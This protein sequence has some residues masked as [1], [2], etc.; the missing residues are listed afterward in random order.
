MCNLYFS[1]SD[2]F[3]PK[4]RL[5]ANGDPLLGCTSE[6]KETARE[7]AKTP[8][9]G[10]TT[11]SWDKVHKQAKEAARTAGGDDGDEQHV[12]GFYKLQFGKYYSKSFRWVL[13]NDVGYAAEFKCQDPF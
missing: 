12:Y 2:L 4:F 8:R 13:E 6:A 11:E 10:R 5:L 9:Q 3:L 7:L 1:A